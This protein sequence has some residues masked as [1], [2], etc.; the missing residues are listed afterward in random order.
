MNLFLTLAQI[1]GGVISGSMAL[2]ADA[3]HNLSDAVALVIAFGARKI[4]RKPRDGEMTFG[5]G[6]AEVVAAM[7]NYVSL[8]V[9][10][11]YLFAEGVSRLFN[12]PDVQGW[13]VVILAGVALAVDLATAALTY[14][15]SKN[16]LNIR[17]AFLHNLAD[18]ATSVAVIFGGIV[19]LIWDWRYIDPIL[20]ILI[21]LYILWHAFVEMRPVIRI[22]MLG[23]PKG[24]DA[25]A[26]AEAIMG[27][28]GVE[29]AHHVH[30]WQIDEHR[31]SV[32]AHVVVTGEAGSVL[33]AVKAVLHEQFEISH[34][35]L[36]VEAPGAGCAAPHSAKYHSI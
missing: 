35:T 21:A 2:I 23:A 8:I 34:S 27:V 7:V 22:L 24:T 26:V 19:I 14:A 16:S 29:D 12:P 17:A 5:Y 33:R 31:S 25:E 28:D 4:A 13:V 20:T 1:V 15:L 3:I 36:E 9:I 32:E 11:V 10:S 18:A 6:R 30:L